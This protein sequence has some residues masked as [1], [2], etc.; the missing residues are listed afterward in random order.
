MLNI[1]LLARG[2]APSTPAQ[3]QWR[4]VPVQNRGRSGRRLVT[5]GLAIDGL[6]VSRAPG[7]W[8][9]DATPPSS[10]SSRAERGSFSSFRPLWV[11]TRP[12]WRTVAFVAGRNRPAPSRPARPQDPAG[13]ASR[14]G[15]PGIRIQ[16]PLIA[17]S[18][19]AAKCATFPAL[20]ACAVHG[21]P[22]RVGMML[23]LHVSH[24]RF[25]LAAATTAT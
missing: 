5:C 15:R 8:G 2:S 14:R 18:R 6:V 10:S 25:A 1:E 17:S 4:A 12:P 13:C 22:Q 16:I 24:R 7:R 11:T 19:F 21:C 20:F 3:R 9:S 23:A